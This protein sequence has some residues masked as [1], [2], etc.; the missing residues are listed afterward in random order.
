MAIGV[1]IICLDVG[2]LKDIIHNNINGISYKFGDLSSLYK[3]FCKI[4]SMKSDELSQLSISAR[5]IAQ[6]IFSLNVRK[7]LQYGD[8]IMILDSILLV[9]QKMSLLRYL[10][11]RL[12]RFIRTLA[13]Y[14][15]YFLRRF[16]DILRR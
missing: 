5:D 16:E 13:Y 11:H 14:Y 10:I 15:N 4:L 9:E 3:M 1:S 6:K 12:G 2:G 7:A 8:S